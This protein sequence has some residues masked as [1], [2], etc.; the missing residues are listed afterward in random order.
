MFVFI[1]ATIL[2]PTD[3]LSKVVEN[4]ATS[5]SLKPPYVWE[6]GS[7]AVTILRWQ[8]PLSCPSSSV[9]CVFPC[10]LLFVVWCLWHCDLPV[11]NSC[12]LCGPGRLGGPGSACTMCMMVCC[13]CV[14]ACCTSIPRL[15]VAL[16]ASLACPSPLLPLHLSFLVVLHFALLLV[17]HGLLCNRCLSF[18]THC[19]HLPV[20]WLCPLVEFFDLR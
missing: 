5:T 7:S 15:C 9:G 4:A 2:L 18:L 10:V 20:L 11:P 1:F 3:F 8:N 14:F 6:N 19:W 17:S 13:R 12:R 16:L